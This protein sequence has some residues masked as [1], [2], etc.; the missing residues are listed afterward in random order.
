MYNLENDHL[1]ISISEKGAE[2]SSIIRKS[3]NKDLLWN[4]D[5]KW[6]NRHSPVLFP[7]VGM[8]WNGVGRFHGQE[9]RMGQHG[10]ARDMDFTLIDVSANQMTFQ[11]QANAASLEKY[12][13]HFSLNISYELDGSTVVVKWHV[14]N[15]DTQDM[16]FQ[17][18]AHPAFAF[19]DYNPANRIHG[20]MRF[21]EESREIYPLSV[22]GEK[23]CVKDEIKE[24]M[25]GKEVALDADLFLSHQ[26]IIIEEH[27]MKSVTLLDLEKKPWIRLSHTAPV[28]GIWSPVH[29]GE[30][31]PFVCIEPWYGRCDLMHFDGDFSERE[32]VEILKPGNNFNAE[33]KIEVI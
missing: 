4:A 17:I 27:P 11:L 9:Y 28:I 31:A 29:E 22:I 3:D 2:L 19:P 14:A 32:W 30:M 25:L 23:G 12:P 15:L 10:F 5:P 33:Y 6:W 21:D 26:T 1:K 8:M 20:Y 7:I 24:T 18:G 16:P 13:F